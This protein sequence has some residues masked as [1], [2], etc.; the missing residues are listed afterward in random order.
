MASFVGTHFQILSQ[1]PKWMPW[2]KLSGF[3]TSSRTKFAD[4]ASYKLVIGNAF[5]VYI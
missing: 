5:S 4:E 3:I 1:G 2:Q